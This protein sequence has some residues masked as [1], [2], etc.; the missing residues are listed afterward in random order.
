MKMTVLGKTIYATFVVV[1]RGMPC[2]LVVAICCR[3][4]A[5]SLHRVVQSHDY[6][7]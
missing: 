5:Y 4:I 3:L 2:E 1:S 6:F 7:S